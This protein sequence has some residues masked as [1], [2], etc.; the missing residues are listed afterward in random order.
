[1]KVSV[2]GHSYVR[3]L[4]SAFEQNTI[5]AH[6]GIELDIEYFGS[7]GA[8]FRFFLD[9]PFHVNALVNSKP[10]FIVV[11]LGGSDLKAHRPL[12]DIYHDC[13]KFY[14]LLR[15]KLPASIII[16]SKIENRFYSR[17]NYHNSPLPEQ[18]DY[19]RRHFNH[20]LK[21][22]KFKDCILQVQGSDRLDNPEFYGDGVHLNADRLNRFFTFIVA[23]V[24]FAYNKF[25][26]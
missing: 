4:W 19:L 11:I 8:T 24:S 10:E 6:E 17:D 15:D 7:S 16:A 21:N 1:M 3:N 9:N 22:K 26:N 5:T 14:E 13:T 20:F 18:F 12:Q 25:L 2:F 23:T